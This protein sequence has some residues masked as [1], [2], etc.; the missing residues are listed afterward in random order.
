V[1]S[2]GPNPYTTSA[3]NTGTTTAWHKPASFQ[4]ISAGVDGLFGTGGRYREDGRTPEE[5]LPIEPTSPGPPVVQNLN[6]P[7]ADVR[8]V[9]RDNLT[10]FASGPLD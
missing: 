5:K 8:Q 4:L 3:A 7:D 10:S 2:P 1:R 6:T 9:E